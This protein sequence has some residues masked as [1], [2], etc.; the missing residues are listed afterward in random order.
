[1][2]ALR[3]SL[4]YSRFYVEGTRPDS[5]HTPYLKAIRAR[6]MRPLDPLEPDPERSGFCRLGEPFE[7]DLTHHDVF[8][9]DYIVL[10]VRTDRWSIPKPLL[11]SKLREAERALLTK[12]GRERLSRK[13]KTELK[14]SVS[15]KL[16]RQTAPSTRAVDLIWSLDEDLVRFFSHAEKSIAIMTD[17]FQKSFGLKL[18]P[19]SPYTLAARLGLAQEH[20]RAW[21][22][23]APSAF[24]SRDELVLEVEV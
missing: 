23:L 12:T 14:E 22:A 20:E 19:E 10:G 6:A 17:L 3:G 5:F 21:S 7:I 18:I 2:P 9:D 15:M 13:E 8:Y 16:R 1:M 24:A 11:R 4:T